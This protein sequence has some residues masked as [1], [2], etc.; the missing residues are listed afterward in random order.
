MP[1][2]S[3]MIAQ[4]WACTSQCSGDLIEVS[5]SNTS[6]SASFSKCSGHFALVSILYFNSSHCL[7]KTSV[8]LDVLSFA[9]PFVLD[10]AFPF[11][12]YWLS[13]RTSTS[14]SL[15]P[16]LVAALEDVVYVPVTTQNLDR[17]RCTRRTV[18]GS[19]IHPAQASKIQN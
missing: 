15:T 3:L 5:F 4:I 6:N 1:C 19:P 8:K 14:S 18:Y 10:L 7:I 12:A 2:F 13:G 11:A 17:D 9:F 16:T